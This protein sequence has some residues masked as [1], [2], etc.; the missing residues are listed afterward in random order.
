MDKA[1][2][3]R[4]MNSRTSITSLPPETIE[5]ILLLLDP[6]DVGAVSQTSHHFYDLIYSPCSRIPPCSI[7]PINQYLWR[8][9]YLAQPFDNPTT[10]YT[11]LGRRMVNLE[12]GEEFDWKTE[13]QEIVRARTIVESYTRR[14][15]GD[16]SHQPKPITSDD[17]A[18]TLR[19]LLKLV[20][21]V[22]PLRSSQDLLNDEK[23]SAN[24]M[25]VAAECRR[26]ACL[27]PISVA[28]DIDDTRE[29]TAT[30]RQQRNML[31]SVFGESLDES[32]QVDDDDTTPIPTLTPET[33]DSCSETE[34]Q[35][36]A[37]LH[38]HLGLTPHDWT[39]EAIRESRAYVYTMANYTWGNDFGPFTEERVL[40][41]KR[42]WIT[43]LRVNWVHVHHIHR[44]VSMKILES[45]PDEQLERIKDLDV[46]IYQLSFPYTQLILDEKEAADR[47]AILKEKSRK[48]KGE[49]KEEEEELSR[50]EQRLEN[51]REKKDF[52][53]DDWAGITGNWKIS[54]CFC[55]HGRLIR[56]NQAL[57]QHQKRSSSSDY[58]S[59]VSALAI[60][61][62]LRTMSVSLH[63]THI[64][65]NTQFPA[66]PVL[67]FGGEIDFGGGVNNVMTGWVRVIDSSEEEDMKRGKEDL[68]LRWHF[69]SGETGN[70]IWSGE[71]VQVGGIKSAYGVLGAWT[72]IFHDVEDPVGPFWL[73]KEYD[74]EAEDL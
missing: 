26:G 15:N 23:M 30:S 52:I 41:S 25:W 38:T 56:F 8:N 60:A 11:S 74:I 29:D 50:L 43:G 45:I 39:D 72:T 67:Y 54:F 64:V 40:D 42:E 2:K 6:L 1:G 44:V 65:Q 10:C 32:M 59:E 27:D 71:G 66:Y 63:I 46:F 73:R 49:G 58:P 12:E 53:D 7:N 48:D 35:L 36:R 68:A 13:L 62:V 70:P 14:A 20:T 22:P 21:N 37:R 34:L 9:L 31:G 47:E 18:R 57:R 24:L 3:R 5:Q 51:G 19:T 33:T 16:T 55:D 69:V 28:D 61:E 4:C 17:R